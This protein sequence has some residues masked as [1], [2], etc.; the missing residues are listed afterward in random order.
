VSAKA[1][2]DRKE[3]P[4]VLA[5]CFLTAAQTVVVILLC[6]DVVRAAFG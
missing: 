2:G 6:I 3:T 4:A 5:L 1:T